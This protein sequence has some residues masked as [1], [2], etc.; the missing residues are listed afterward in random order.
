MR[1]R[2]MTYKVGLS[3]SYILEEEEEAGSPPPVPQETCK[4]PEKR[5]HLKEKP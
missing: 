3:E 4:G 5:T 1:V 2:R